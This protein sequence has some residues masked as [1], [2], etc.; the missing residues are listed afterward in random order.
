MLVFLLL[1][2][3]EG[4]RIRYDSYPS[5]AGIAQL[6]ER[7]LAKVEVESSRLFSRSIFLLPSPRCP[8]ASCKHCPFG[9]GQFGRLHA[10][11]DRGRAACE[12]GRLGPPLKELRA[13]Q[14]HRETRRFL[15]AE[16]RGRLPEVV[17]RGRLGTEDAFT[18]FDA[19]EVDL[20]N[21]LL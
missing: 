20:K 13:G 3:E 5:N 11:S 4:A 18:P 16:T 14:H 2:P 7:N 9:S 12:V 21:A 15:C 1:R 10:R 17:L 8:L 6:V 19:V